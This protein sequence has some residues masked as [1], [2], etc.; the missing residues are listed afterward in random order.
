MV[1]GE[2]FYGVAESGVDYTL[3]RKGKPSKLSLIDHVWARIPYIKS[4]DNRM[5]VKLT[6]SITGPTM[7]RSE[8]L[9]VKLDIVKDIGKGEPIFA[10]A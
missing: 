3:N 5:N 8:M 4:N 1:T 6:R 7:E 2:T 9:V 10:C